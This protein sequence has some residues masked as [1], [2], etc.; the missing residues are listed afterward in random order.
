VPARRLD[1]HQP[2]DSG[3]QVPVPV[4]EQRHQ[5]R[6][7]HRTDDRRVD[8]DA[9][10]QPGRQRLEVRPRPGRQGGEGEE[11]DQRGAGDQAAGAGDAGDDR[12]VGV[13]GAV[14]LLADTAEDEDL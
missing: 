10:A 8:E 6:H 3:R 11:Q 12:L 2:G 9:D 1:P 14:V 4:A 13:A 5:R 7:E